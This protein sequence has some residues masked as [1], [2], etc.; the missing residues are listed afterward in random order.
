[1]PVSPATVISDAL[2][3]LNSASTADLVF[4]TEA[5]LYQFV[6]EAVRRA[7]RESLAFAAVAILPVTGGSTGA[8]MPT[9]SST[10]IWASWNGVSLR[11]ASVGELEARDDSWDTATGTPSHWTVEL[12][13][14]VIRLYPIPPTDGVLLALVQGC[15]PAVALGGAAL[16]A[17]HPFFGYLVQ[18]VIGAARGKVSDATMP[19]IASHTA[20]R[21]AM[22]L[23]TFKQY[24]GTG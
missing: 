4:W 22:Y 8:A 14:G 10:A 11:S 3:A 15:P 7:A 20:Q 1:M 17:V 19:E 12:G 21:G 6:D 23:D 18:E 5:E 24:W 2:P 16:P 9:G 13:T